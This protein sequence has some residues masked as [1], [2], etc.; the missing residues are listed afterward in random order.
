[1]Q[2]L[3]PIARQE[4]AREEPLAGE[5][6]VC[7]PDGEQVPDG[8]PGRGIAPG[9]VR[10]AGAGHAQQFAAQGFDP[11]KLVVR[12]DGLPVFGQNDA[13]DLGEDVEFSASANAV[14]CEPSSGERAP[15][16][17]AR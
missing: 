11:G 8:E 15:E 3:L 1:M 10:H 6:L 16:Q 13:V 4:R 2:P 5:A 14:T 9:L 17:P 12:I 7:R